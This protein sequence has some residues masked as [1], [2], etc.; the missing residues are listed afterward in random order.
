MTSANLCP[1]DHALWL[2]AHSASFQMLAAA[3]PQQI[4]LFSSEGG[5]LPK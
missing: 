4:P 2:V 3:Y 5:S 1:L